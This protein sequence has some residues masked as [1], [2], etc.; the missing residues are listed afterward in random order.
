MEKIQQAIREHFEGLKA[1]GSQFWF[2]IQIGWVRDLCIAGM[3]TSDAWKW[4]ED[5]LNSAKKP[6]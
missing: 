5:L 2:V 3:Q 1:A 4:T 6:V